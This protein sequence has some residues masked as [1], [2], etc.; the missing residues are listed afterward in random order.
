MWK[1]QYKREEKTDWQAY[2]SQ[3]KSRFASST[4]KFTLKKLLYFIEKYK[5]NPMDVMELGEEV[6]V[7]RK[8]Y[9]IHVKRLLKVIQLW[10]TAFW[11]W[12]DSKRKI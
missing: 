1:K 6:A 5:Q 10:I 7:L 3:P 8:L 4:Q 2:Y 12:K 9:L 11:Q